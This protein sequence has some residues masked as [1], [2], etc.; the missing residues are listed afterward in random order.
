MRLLDKIS[1][2]KEIELE[3]DQS[4][5]SL[6]SH[7]ITSSEHAEKVKKGNEENIRPKKKVGV[8]K[9]GESKKTKRPG[10]KVEHVSRRRKK[11]PL[12]RKPRESQETRETESLTEFSASL[13][14]PRPDSCERCWKYV[15]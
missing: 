13:K 5:K 12:K 3:E 8:K 2:I 9:K 1:P 14:R 7:K 6:K 11:S 4:L 15:N 10:E